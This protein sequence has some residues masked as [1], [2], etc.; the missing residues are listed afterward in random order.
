[1]EAVNAR[2]QAV[3]R[4]CAA[5]RASFFY[6]AATVSVWLW[7]LRLFN[8]W[9]GHQRNLAARFVELG[10]IECFAR[11]ETLGK[12]TC[13]SMGFPSTYPVAAGLPTLLIKAMTMQ[14]LSLSLLTADAAVDGLFL[15]AGLVGAIWF[16]RSLG[17]ERWLALLGAYLILSSPVVQGQDNY[18]ALRTGFL[19]VPAYVWI[20]H[21]SRGALLT[22]THP[23]VTQ[24]A[25]A[26]AVVG[27]RVFALFTDGYS[28]V[29]SVLLSGA[30]LVA[31]L[32]GAWR[33][34]QVVE[35][36]SATGIFFLSVGVAYWSFTRYFPAAKDFAVMP[37]DFFRGQGVDLYALAV[38]SRRF[39]IPYLLGWVQHAS[40]WQ[41]YT[42][43]PPL[44]DTYLGLT[45]VG[46][47]VFALLYAR[48]CSHPLRREVV[49]VLVIGLA[50]LLV[51]LGPSLKVAD[52]RPPGTFDLANP[53]SNYLMPAEAATMN[54]GTDWLYQRFPGIRTMRAL[55][56]WHLLVRIALVV[57]FLAGVQRL[58]QRRKGPL[59]CLLCL[60]AVVELFPNVILTSSAGTRSM[61]GWKDFESHVA[62][63]LATS[64]LPGERVLLQPCEA[65][66][67]RNDF[68]ASP[69]CG[70]M[71]AR[72]YNAAGDK[73]IGAVFPFWPLEVQQLMRQQG[74]TL[75]NI[76]G[77][78]RRGVLDVVVFTRF[79]LWEQAHS[80]PP[81]AHDD[82]RA[83]DACR[84]LLGP[85]ASAFRR[86]WFLV[87]REQDFM[88]TLAA[89]SSSRRLSL[90]H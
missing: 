86:D 54:L 70:H 76:A 21:R 16:L 42:D 77:L 80:W 63:P 87:L 82:A 67:F 1:M 34:R 74:D 40:P 12:T 14:G 59:A 66:T 43:G 39:L 81:T 32:V 49:T 18:G 15:A 89:H 61:R 79:S 73:S 85:V 45:M 7:L 84:K 71:G 64:V 23:R 72:C 53:F 48:G 41:A 11:Q 26:G 68:L 47:V 25:W 90:G 36:I 83:S 29:L 10:L 46:G 30:L 4:H 35:A 52:F 31:W 65:P 55:Y 60:L 38:P 2:L 20:D 58:L 50:A 33:A 88:S 8:L 69:L 27:A 57:V 56:R 51:S 28:F 24:L 5:E 78:F 75:D 13:D 3:L 17:I 6:A 19:L 62:R 9:A 37:V 44:T 22:S